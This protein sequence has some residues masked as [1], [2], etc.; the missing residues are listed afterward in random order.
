MNFCASCRCHTQKCSGARSR[1]TPS[2]R[3][4]GEKARAEPHS[5]RDSM[6]SAPKQ[7]VKF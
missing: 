7:A 2:T 6:N 1:C 4:R 3:R 5:G